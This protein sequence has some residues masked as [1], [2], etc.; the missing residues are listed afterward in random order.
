M[1]TMFRRTL[2]G[3]RL[4]PG[5]RVNGRWVEGAPTSIS[6]KAS[7]Q[8]VSEHDLAFL[9]ISRRERK[10]YTIYTDTKL[11]ALTAGTTNPDRVNIENEVYEV[12]IAAPWRN[13]VISYYKYIIQKLDAVEA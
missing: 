4:A 7:V 1:G 8:P 12:V 3:Q 6:F 11:N 13:N 5:A 10:S 2:S 9:D